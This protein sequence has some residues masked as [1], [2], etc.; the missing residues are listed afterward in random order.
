[1]KPIKEILSVVAGAFAVGG[2]CY[3]IFLLGKFLRETLLVGWFAKP[4]IPYGQTTEPV[5]TQ[6]IHAILALIITALGVVV[7]WA[8][9]YVFYMVGKDI[10]NWTIRTSNHIHNQLQK[11]N[12]A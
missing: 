1:M 7:V 5:A 4:Y 2:G 11:G 8:I 3:G 10:V 6:I 9:G 12:T